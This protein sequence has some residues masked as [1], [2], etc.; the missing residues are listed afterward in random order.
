MSVEELRSI[1]L[2]MG[3]AKSVKDEID[4][5]GPAAAVPPT[6]PAVHP[7]SSAVAAAAA[8]AAAACLAPACDGKPRTLMSSNF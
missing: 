8:A 6:S 2:N 3:N 5:L 1:G 4:A 7:H